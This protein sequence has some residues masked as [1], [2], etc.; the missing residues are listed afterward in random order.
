MSVDRGGMLNL[1]TP[2]KTQIKKSHSMG[3]S[4]ALVE[5]EIWDKKELNKSNYQNNK[6]ISKEVLQAAE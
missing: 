5:I 6:N 3:N 1:L 4:T 2:K